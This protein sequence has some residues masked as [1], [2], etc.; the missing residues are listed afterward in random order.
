MSSAMPTFN[1]CLGRNPKAAIF[2]RYDG[3]VSRV[4]FSALESLAQKTIRKLLLNRGRQIPL[5]ELSLG[6]RHVEDLAFRIFPFFQG[7]QDGGDRIA[8]V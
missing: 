7:E 1:V 8:H 5:R 3:V 2:F 4:R 6:I